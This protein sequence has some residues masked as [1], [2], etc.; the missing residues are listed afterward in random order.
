MPRCGRCSRDCALDSG[1]TACSDATSCGSRCQSRS[2]SIVEAARFEI[3]RALRAL[4]D[5]DVRSAWALAQ[6]PLN[7]A[8]RGLLP[9]SQADWLEPHRRELEDIRLQALEVIGRAGLRLGGTQLS[10]VN[11]AAHGLIETEP[12]RESGYVLLMEALAAQGNVAEAL[13][14]FERLRS[15]LRD[16]LGTTPSPETLAVHERLLRSGARG[17]AGADRCPGSRPACEGGRR[18]RAS[19]RA[20]RPGSHAAGRTQTGAR[21]AR[22]RVGDR[23]RWSDGATGRAGRSQANP[24]A[25][26]R[27]RHR[28]DAA[29]RRACESRARAGRARAGG[30]L[31][32]GERG[33][34]SALPGGASPLRAE[35]AVRSA[36]GQRPRVRLRARAPGAGAAAACAGASAA[37]C[38]RARDGALPAV[39]GGRRIACRDLD[40][41]RRCCWFSTTCTGPTSRR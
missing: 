3:E 26:G 23:R 33:A 11:R 19:G 5:G 8:G 35:R 12:Y 37:A 39:R 29:D 40:E 9:G 15:L 25:G 1:A 20:A 2:G 10:S 13:R 16:E 7:I 18:G 27:G 32:R 14:V 34:L 6:V 24:A 28:Q 4:E 41:Q 31:A 21:G 38:R 17:W 36:A 22:A 30:P